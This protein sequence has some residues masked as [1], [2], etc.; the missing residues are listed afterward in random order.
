MASL[1]LWA[2]KLTD[3]LLNPWKFFAL[4]QV[5]NQIRTEYRPL[6]VR[7]ASILVKT[8]KVDDFVRD[9]APGLLD[10]EQIPKLK[11]AWRYDVGIWIKGLNITLLLQLRA[12]YPSFD[13]EFVAPEVPAEMRP[14]GGFCSIHNRNLQGCGCPNIRGGWE[15]YTNEQMDNI[16]LLHNFIYNDTKAWLET[17]RENKVTVSCSQ[18]PGTSRITFLCHYREPRR[19]EANTMKRAR[20]LLKSWGLLSLPRQTRM[21]FKMMWEEA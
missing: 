12:H 20:D 21:E 5:C 13:C 11:I 6:W 3:D 1:T 18:P 17:I 16:E 4:T 7:D 19:D 2:F 14:I 15:N 8:R 10:L 9:F